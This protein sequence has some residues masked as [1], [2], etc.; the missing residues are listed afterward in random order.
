MFQPYVFF[1][2]LALA[3]DQPVAERASIVFVLFR[4][5]VRCIAVWAD[6]PLHAINGE[7]HIEIETDS[8][9]RLLI[10][11]IERLDLARVV[12]DSDN[13]CIVRLLYVIDQRVNASPSLGAVVKQN[14]FDFVCWHRC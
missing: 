8:V 4:C 7:R 2:W 14:W 3:S 12:V 5:P 1:V 13:P 9:V 10:D 6:V 11:V